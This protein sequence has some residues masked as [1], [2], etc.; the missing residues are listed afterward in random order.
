MGKYPVDYGPFFSGQ[1]TSVMLRWALW[2]ST[3]YM[4]EDF[5]VFGIGWDAFWMTYPDYNYFIQDPTVIIYHAHN[6]YLQVAA[7]TGPI[8][9]CLLLAILLGHSRNVQN[10]SAFPFH[11]A[12]V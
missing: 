9:L 12:I 6:L 5:P 10:K 11:I 1:D 2:D 7:E 4:I 3:M 8:S